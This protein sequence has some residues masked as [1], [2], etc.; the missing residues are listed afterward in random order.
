MRRKGDL[1]SV[2]LRSKRQASGDDGTLGVDVTDR[3][4]VR[5][6]IASVR[7]DVIVHLASIAGAACDEDLQKTELVNVQGVRIVA[8]E[9][10]NHGVS[11]IVF[12]STGAV[13]G[14]KYHFPVSESAPISPESAYAASKYSAERV[15]QEVVGESEGL[16]VIILRV[17]NIFGPYFDQSLVSRLWTSSTGAPV[18]LRGMEEFVRDYSHVSAVV[19]AFEASTTISLEKSIAVFNIGSGVPFSTSQ[20]VETLGRERPLRYTAQPGPYSYSCAD[21]SVAQDKLKLLSF[22]PSAELLALA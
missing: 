17:F 11:R 9:A 3:E 13:Y 21:I 22:P 20:L 5:D 12:A 1:D 7:P 14:D 10:R 16:E 2:F 19:A 6:A 8:E 18:T 15:L 4:S